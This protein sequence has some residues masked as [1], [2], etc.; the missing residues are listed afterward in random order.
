M[1]CTLLAPCKWRN[2]QLSLEWKL[3]KSYEKSYEPQSADYRY[4]LYVLNLNKKTLLKIIFQHFVIVS[5]Y[6]WL[7]NCCNWCKSCCS[8][9]FLA[10]ISL[11][12][13]TSEC[14]SLQVFSF[15]DF[16]HFHHCCYPKLKLY[17]QTVGIL[18]SL[19]TDFLSKFDG[20]YRRWNV[21]RVNCWPILHNKSG[22]K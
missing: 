4:F 3:I 8:W 11:S 22:N 17:T 21:F 6:L 14:L 7:P 10:G 20:V 18:V 1:P 12:V 15:L 9:V 19:W 5:E 13:S 2:I 16:C